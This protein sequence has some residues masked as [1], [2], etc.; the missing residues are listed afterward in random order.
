MTDGADPV[1]PERARSVI[2]TLWGASFAAALVIPFVL[3]AK[4]AIEA[5]ALKPSL[6]NLGDMYAPHIGI[7]L[8]YYFAARRR[9]P[10]AVM[11]RT[12][13]LLA[14]AIS[15][16]WN[17]SVFALILPPLW[18]GGALVEATVTARDLTLQFAWV[19]GPAL[20]YFFAKAC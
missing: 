20:G 19:L 6:G 11:T 13:F 1:A 2:A 5:D 4:S 14:I 7:I 8:A 3:Y 10:R 18:G 15:A 9:A 17:L 12:P 16:V